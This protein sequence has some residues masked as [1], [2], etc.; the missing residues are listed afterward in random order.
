MA[1]IWVKMHAKLC[2]CIPFS[3][4]PCHWP[5]WLFVSKFKIKRLYLLSHLFTRIS[6]SL[7]ESTRRMKNVKSLPLSLVISFLT[8]QRPACENIYKP[9]THACPGKFFLLF[10]CSACYW[11]RV[12]LPW[13]R[14]WNPTSSAEC[15]DLHNCC[16]G[17]QG[18]E[19]APLSP[20]E[21][22]IATLLLDPVTSAWVKQHR[23]QQADGLCVSIPPELTPTE[24]WVQTNTVRKLFVTER[25]KERTEHSEQHLS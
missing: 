13:L 5:S 6:P 16:R 1:I 3:Q 18:A 12:H 21:R 19:R 8:L 15:Q 17:S 25:G 2:I 9:V 7:L 23:A 20:V 11:R 24:P 22:P 4:V 14:G 10:H